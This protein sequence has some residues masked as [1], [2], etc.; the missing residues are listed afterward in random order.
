MTD[1]LIKLFR[2]KYKL[3]QA[4]TVGRKD[5]NGADILFLL[6]FEEYCELYTSKGKFPRFPWCL[7]RVNDL[8][9]YELGNVFLSTTGRNST[10]A[11]YGET[12]DHLLTDFAL[13]YGMRRSQVRRRLITGTLTMQF[14]IDYMKDIK[15]L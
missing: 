9:N 12:D 10:E 3:K 2:Q 1:Y 7:S 14:I 11:A 4:S 13:L 15:I 5:K 6:S 8:G